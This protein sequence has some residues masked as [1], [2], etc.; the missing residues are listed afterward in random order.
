MI[1]PE[2]VGNILAILR[3]I[4]R[5]ELFDVGLPLADDEWVSFRADPYKYFLQGDELRQGLTTCVINLRMP[6]QDTPVRCGV[7]YAL[8]ESA[9]PERWARWYDHLAWSL[10]F[11][12]RVRGW[13]GVAITKS[14]L[15]DG[16][17]LIEYEPGPDSPTAEV[18][19][20]LHK[21]AS[22]G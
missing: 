4:D 17:L 10:G 3:S 16:G 18:I 1:T 12:S 8:P 13:T 14:A 2:Q 5:H 9:N 21:E 6:V 7:W 20:R 19:E 15:E 22:N 11:A